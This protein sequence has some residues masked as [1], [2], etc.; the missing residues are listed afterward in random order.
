MADAKVSPHITDG[1]LSELK[2]LIS[3]ALTLFGISHPGTIDGSTIHMFL[4]FANEV[5]ED[6]NAHPYWE[7]NDPVDYFINIDQQS[8]AIPDLILVHGMLAKYA[9]QQNNQAKINTWLPTYQRT[10]NSLLWNRLNGN[11]PIEVR[12][13]DKSTNRSTINGRPLTDS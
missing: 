2:S 10:L 12:P 4:L 1:D 7:N 11:T 13:L 5:V 3:A 9:L 6:V 8:T